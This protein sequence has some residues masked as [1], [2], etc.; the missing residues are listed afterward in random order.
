MFQTT[1]Q[2][3]SFCCWNGPRHDEYM[4]FLPENIQDI[5]SIDSARFLSFLRMNI[6]IFI[7]GLPKKPPKITP[8]ILVNSPQRSGGFAEKNVST[9]SMYSTNSL[10]NRVA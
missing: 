1:N 6:S 4:G 5:L 8:Q 2:V 7:V 9:Y 10:A 3:V